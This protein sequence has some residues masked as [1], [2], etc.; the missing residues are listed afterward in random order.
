[1]NFLAHA[2]ATTALDNILASYNSRTTTSAKPLEIHCSKRA[3]GWRALKAEVDKS[4]DE[5]LARPEGT[6]GIYQTAAGKRFYLVQRD[7]VYDENIHTMII[8]R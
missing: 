5:W 2:P 1:M 4:S 8:L 6:W 7:S 3:P